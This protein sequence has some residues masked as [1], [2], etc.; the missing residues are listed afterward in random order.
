[1]AN[2]LYYK[3]SGAYSN[4]TR[5]TISVEEAMRE[6]DELL[7]QNPDLKEY[8]H[9]IERRLNAAGNFDNRMAVISLMMEANMANLHHQLIL[10]LMHFYEFLDQSYTFQIN[11]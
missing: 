1:M 3:P 2:R 10:M 8:Q 7:Q 11:D 4:S 9:E 6:L 5:P